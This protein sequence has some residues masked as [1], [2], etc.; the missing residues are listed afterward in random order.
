M[1]RLNVNERELGFIGDKGEPKSGLSFTASKTGAAAVV[2]P[3]DVAG[4]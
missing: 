2:A 4:D 3:R 1:I